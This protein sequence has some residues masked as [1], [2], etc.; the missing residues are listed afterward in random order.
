MLLGLGST[1]AYYSV[2]AAEHNKDSTNAES[3]IGQAY[4]CPADAVVETIVLSNAVD[5]GASLFTLKSP[6]LDRRRSR[7]NTLNKAIELL[8]HPLIDEHAQDLVKAMQGYVAVANATLKAGTNNLKEAG[9]DTMRNIWKAM[10][11]SAKSANALAV[12]KQAYAQ[13]AILDAK[14]M[15]SVLRQYTKME[16]Q[17]LSALQTSLV[18]AA[19]YRGVFQANV[20][21]GSF[22]K[23]GRLLGLFVR[24]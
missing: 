18:S 20:E 10:Q 6:E 21:K 13:K 23:K 5:Q 24:S 7:L 4:Y 16:E 12:K 8:E 15:I 11:V 19:P 2:N 3:Q 17:L 22:Q 14:D 9:N 1:L